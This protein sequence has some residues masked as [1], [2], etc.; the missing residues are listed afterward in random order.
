M[1]QVKVSGN[2]S[3]TG[4]LTI[5]APNT[6][7]DYTLTLPAETGTVVTT[8]TTTGI[9]AS[10]IST[11]TLAA[12]RL[13]AGS[14]LQVVQNT[15]VNT[16]Y[17]ISTGGSA[18]QTAYTALTDYKVIITPSSASSKILL[19]ASIPSTGFANTSASAVQLFSR[20]YRNGTAL[21]DSTMNHYGL[22]NTYVIHSWS[23]LDSP[24]TTSSITYTVYGSGAGSTVGD[25]AWRRVSGTCTF[26]A[27][28]IAG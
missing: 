7:T 4:I 2:A 5:A 10:A 6:N 27:M 25:Y 16:N 8:G 26:I 3:G 14:V 20:W 12:A 21:S 28:E 1:S 17:N 11:G 22:N 18:S 13:P 24:A 23:Y 19:F 15:G 9:S